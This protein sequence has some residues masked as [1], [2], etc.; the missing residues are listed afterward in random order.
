MPVS[1]LLMTIDSARESELRECLAVDPRTTLGATF[2]QRLVLVLETASRRDDTAAWA[3]L[4]GLPGVL[5]IDLVWISIDPADDDEVR[6][7]RRR[8]DEEEA[9]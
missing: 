9:A 8:N 4:K 6:E 1:S 7:P 3:W 2:G 5:F